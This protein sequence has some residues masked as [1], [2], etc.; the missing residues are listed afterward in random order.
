[1]AS[2]QNKIFFRKFSLNRLFLFALV[3]LPRVNASSTHYGECALFPGW[4]FSPEEAKLRQQKTAHVLRVPVEK[5]I[6]LGNEVFIEFVLV[7]N[8]RF[9]MGTPSPIEP[10]WEDFRSSIRFNRAVTISVVVFVFSI[11]FLWLWRVFR[12]KTKMQISLK[13]LIIF[14]IIINIASVSGVKWWKWNNNFN[15]AKV[16]FE[17]AQ[18]RFKNSENWE[19][20]AHWVIIGSPFYF[21]KYEISQEQYSVVMGNNPGLPKNPQFPVNGVSWEDAVNFCKKASD[22]AGVKLRLPT[23]A[24]WEFACRGGSLTQFFFGD[25]TENLNRVAWFSENAKS[26]QKV[27]LKEKNPFGLFDIHGNVWEWCNDSFIAYSLNIEG[28]MDGRSH[29]YSE[30]VLRGGSWGSSGLSC[31]SA[32]RDKATPMGSS[33]IWGF[34]LVLCIE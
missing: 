33:R 32:C 20:P 11:F 30:R 7:P 10:N 23:E 2:K 16:E 21:G 4:P 13:N 17:I 31:R 28:N 29:P 12:L 34:R 22:K 9:C 14:L 6:N 26:I 25:S 8:G 19:K 27:G 18:T 1:M 15:K 3:Y 5:L 24:E